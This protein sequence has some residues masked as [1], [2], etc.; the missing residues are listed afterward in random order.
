LS[1]EYRLNLL[2]SLETAFVADIAPKILQILFNL[3]EFMGH[4]GIDSSLPIYIS[5]L[6][7]LL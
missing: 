6:A 5:I 1:E 3:A 2:C 7:V 4:D